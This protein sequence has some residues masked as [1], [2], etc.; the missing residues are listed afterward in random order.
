MRHRTNAVDCSRAR[1]TLAAAALLLVLFASVAPSFHSEALGHDCAVCRLGSLQ[2]DPVAAPASAVRLP[3]S[4]WRMAESTCQLDLL[5]ASK[6]CP[7][8]AP[9]Q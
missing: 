1:I 3:T 5:A 6:S 7:P 8:R 9:P 4:V 2:G